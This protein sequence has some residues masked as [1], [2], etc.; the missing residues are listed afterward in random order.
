[1]SGAPYPPRVDA[2]RLGLVARMLRQRQQIR[3]QDLGERAGVGRAKVSRLER[4]EA[5]SLT[6]GT[7]LAVFA[8]LEGRVDLHP[9]WRGAALDRLLDEGHARLMSRVVEVLK[10]AGWATEVEVSFAHYGERGAIDILAWHAP[11]RT[12]LVVEVKTELGSVEG[13]LRPL[14]VKVRLAPDI[15]RKRLGQRPDS[16]ARLVVLPEERTARRGVE[17]HATL[18][19]GALPHRSREVRRWLRRPVGTLGGLWFLSHAHGPSTTR[20]P[21]SISRVR[22][23]PPRSNRAA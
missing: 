7:I 13:L 23:R 15:C 18:L 12:A 22:A 3:Q 10:S 21:S 11:S 2:V 4:G 20:N 19:L 6:L 5:S 8:A 1:M 17:R 9:M 16:V 14:D